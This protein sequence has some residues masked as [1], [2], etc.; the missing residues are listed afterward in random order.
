MK[1]LVTAVILVCTSL[2]VEAQNIEVSN[3]TIRR[4]GIEIGVIK[5]KRL[6]IFS[7][8]AVPE[9]MDLVQQALPKIRRFKVDQYLFKELL[10]FDKD[11][12]AVMYD[13]LQVGTWIVQNDIEI[14]IT[15]SDI[16]EEFVSYCVKKLYPKA[17]QFLYISFDFTKERMKKLQEE[18]RIL[19]QIEKR[20]L[21]RFYGQIYSKLEGNLDA[22]E[23]IYKS[24]D[25]GE[26]FEYDIAIFKSTENEREYSGQ[27]LASTDIDFK[28]GDLFLA[29]EKTAQTNLFF[30]KYSTK[31][32][33][34]FENKTAILEGAVL[35][36]GV[37]SFIKMYPAEGEKRRYLEVNPL[38]DWET[39]GSG[40][41][42]NSSGFIATNNHVIIGAK[43][44]RVAFQ[45]DSLN[46]DAKIYSQ[47]E[48][49]DVAIIQITDERFKKSL[50]P[51]KWNTDITLGQEVFTLGYP[52]ASK[53]SVNVKVVDGIVS[54]L[55]GPDGNQSFFQTTLPV[56]YGNSGGPCFNSKGEILGLTTQILWD[57]GEKVDNVAY[58]IKT[59]N[60]TDLSEN[61]IRNEDT[62]N[63]NVEEIGLEKILE[64]LIP[65]SA[66]IKVN[67]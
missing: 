37:K 58:I 15:S 38:V 6:T 21:E 17:S 54:G 32:G 29:L 61:I 49:S 34:D 27:V 25:Q 10:R 57:R 31:D 52:V 3:D 35:T 14:Q 42:I 5:S 45:N 51:I 18:Q 33:K 8:E 13:G 53:M 9:D 56:W 62:G 44:I 63:N 36:M 16:S 23:G 11:P 1:N 20:R 65:Y 26:S 40:V 22:V 43:Q 47:N 66:F 2:L 48:E 55:S 39:S 7:N 28:T 4:D 46:Y 67:Y 50:I 64:K 19:D 60:L 12:N 59:K 41:L 24:I 30:A